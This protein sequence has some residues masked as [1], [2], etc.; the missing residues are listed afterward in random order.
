[1]SALAA[2]GLI[3]P[4]SGMQVP[5]LPPSSLGGGMSESI[6]AYLEE[7]EAPAD[8]K[9]A[10]WG[11]LGRTVPVSKISH[12]MIAAYVDFIESHG[13]LVKMAIPKRHQTNEFLIANENAI[14]NAKM[15]VMRAEFPKSEREMLVTQASTVESAPQQRQRKKF[16]GVF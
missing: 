15:A 11:L 10:W 6:L 3:P 13:E 9:Q 14:F 8:V 1:M 16:M 4:S 12:K 7:S 2:A 5:Q